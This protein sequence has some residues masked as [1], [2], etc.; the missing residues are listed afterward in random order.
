MIGLALLPAVGNLT[1]GLVAEFTRTPDKRLNKALH[2]ASGIVLAVVSVELMPEVLAVLS[3]WTVGVAFGVGGIAYIV[4]E[5]LVDKIQQSQGG[6]RE[7]PRHVDDL[8]RR[9]Y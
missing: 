1:G 6:A 5:S 9:V 4:I 7:K 2:A 8:Y 3:G